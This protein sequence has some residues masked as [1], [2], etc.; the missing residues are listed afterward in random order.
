MAGL[1]GSCFFLSA[2]TLQVSQQSSQPQATPLVQAH[3]HNDYYHT[4]PL[5]D[6]VECGFCSFEADIFLVDDQLLVG[7]FPFELKPERSLERLYLEPLRHLVRKNGGRVY[8]NGP[9]VTLLV[10]IKNNGREVYSKLKQVLT[11]YEDIISVVDDGQLTQRA[12]RIVVSGDRPKADIAAD[13]RRYVGIDGRLSDLDS[14]LPA[15]LVPLISDRW[16][17]HFRWTGNGD[18]PTEERVKLNEI[19]SKAH[20]AGRTVRFWATPDRESVWAELQKA[21]VDHINTD[22]L[23]GLR[24][25]LARTAPKPAKTP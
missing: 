9:T 5:L 25:F 13:S 12:V 4:R 15:H 2:L 21:G 22:D 11:E 17:S 14:S 18:F 24:T 6:A 7:H 3:A 19:V 10:D 8:R 23:K 1:L 20:S 16:G